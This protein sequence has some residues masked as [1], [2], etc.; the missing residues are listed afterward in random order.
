MKLK[1]KLGYH[2]L[3]TAKDE[4]FDLLSDL[5]LKGTVHIHIKKCKYCKHVEISLDD[6]KLY[7]KI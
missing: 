2:K 6:I 4:T 1:C 7:E 3:I 5:S